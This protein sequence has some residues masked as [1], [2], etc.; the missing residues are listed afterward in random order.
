MGEGPA[1][2]RPTPR[3]RAPWWRR[4]LAAPLLVVAFG[5]TLT[6]SA[7]SAATPSSLDGPG[8]LTLISTHQLDPR[9]QELT[10]STPVLTGDTDVRV[11]LPAGYATSTQRYP[12]LYLLNGTLGNETDWTV[13]GDAEA[14]T[15]GLPLIVVMPSGGAGGFYTNWY[16]GGAGGPPEYETYHIDEL[17]PWIDEHFRTLPTRSERGIAGVSMGGF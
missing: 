10:F 8:A 1:S 15:A 14:A 4:A 9:L 13:Q 16:N 11:L 7:A 3:L 6:L 2:S 12:V 5:L 17:L